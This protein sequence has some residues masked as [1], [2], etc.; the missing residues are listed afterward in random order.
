MKYL[1]MGTGKVLACGVCRAALASKQQVFSVPGAEGVTG[2]YVNPHGYAEPLLCI[3]SNYCSFSSFVLLLP[4]H[5]AVHQ[6]IT[7]RDVLDPRAVL[8]HGR[9]C[10]ED[11]WFPGYAWTIASCARCLNHLGWRFTLVTPVQSAQSTR[12][13]QSVTAARRALPAALVGF[14][15]TPIEELWR[16]LLQGQGD[17]T[18][19]LEEDE[20]DDEDVQ[21]EEEEEWNESEYSGSDVY[22][23]GDYYEEEEV[24]E[25]EEDAMIEGE[26]G[27]EESEEGDEINDDRRSIHSGSEHSSTHSDRRD[28]FI[29]AAEDAQEVSVEDNARST[30][31]ASSEENGEG[32]QGNSVEEDDNAL[33]NSSSSSSVGNSAD[34]GGGDRVVSFW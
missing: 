14:A 10:T 17:D 18:D 1:E 15:G 9:P 3:K 34:E 32:E 8:L 31:R 11:S 26:N 29:G 27:R 28:V 2:A 20:E 33:L 23:G 5:S 12:S 21:E 24:E 4:M 25:G 30:G 13:S 7:V 6:T 16:N 19:G 22:S